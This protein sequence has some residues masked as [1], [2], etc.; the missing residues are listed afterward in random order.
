MR[1][2]YNP[3][4]REPA[5]VFYKQPSRR[6]AMASALQTRRRHH[7]APL[8]EPPR[9]QGLRPSHRCVGVPCRPTNYQPLITKDGDRFQMQDQDQ[10]KPRVSS[11]LLGTIHLVTGDSP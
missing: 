8:T 6:I 1:A 9:D 7:F 10:V 4:I 11:G 3:T 2:S 5:I